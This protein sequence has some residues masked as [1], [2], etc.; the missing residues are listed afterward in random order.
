MTEY[1]TTKEVAAYLRINEKK[2]YALVSEGKI[3]A[4]RISGKWLYPRE[5]LDAWLAKSTHVPPGGLVQ[6]LLDQMVLVQ[7]SD[8][9]LLSLCISRFQEKTAL[10]VLT[11]QVG[12]TAGLT[13]LKNGLAHL[14]GCHLPKD[15][16]EATLDGLDGY[17]LVDLFVRTQGLLFDKKTSRKANSLADVL[18]PGTRLAMRQEGS[19]TYRLAQGII[20]SLGMSKDDLELVGPFYSHDDIACAVRMGRADC[21]LAIEL[22][23]ARTDLGFIPYVDERYQLAVPLSVMTHRNT[24]N[25]F[26]YMFN[27]VPTFS[28]SDFPGYDWSNLGKI[29]TMRSE[30]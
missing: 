21:G 7:G 19:G 17:S 25:F 9:P 23:A 13:A 28:T 27:T 18:K 24:G 14:A 22:A 8:D 1:M 26:D 11:A 3:P 20:E 10:P 2:I 5:I 16:I 6:S 29:I 30:A 15:R 12:S 4:T